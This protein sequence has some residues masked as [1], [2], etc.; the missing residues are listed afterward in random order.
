MPLTCSLFLLAYAVLSIRQVIAQT[1]S[2]FFTTPSQA[3]LRLGGLDGGE[4]LGRGL[5]AVALRVVMDPAPQVLAG[6]LH[7]KLRLP[8]ELL[9]GQRG[10][11]RQVQNITRP[12][13]DNLVLEVAADDG[14]EGI[15]HLEHGAAAAGAQVPGLDAGLLL[16]EVV[17]GN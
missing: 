14:A 6:L 8:V 16:A 3:L 1:K 2:P 11:G 15:D 5:L 9:V 10:V 13:G 4:E 12:A 7:G 17:E